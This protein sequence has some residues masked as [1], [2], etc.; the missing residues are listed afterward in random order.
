MPPAGWTKYV[1]ITISHRVYRGFHDDPDDNRDVT[2]DAQ[3]R[4]VPRVPGILSCVFVDDGKELQVTVV[5][6][7]KYWRMLGELP[8]K[9]IRVQLLRTDETATGGAKFVCRWKR[10]AVVGWSKTKVEVICV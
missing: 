1:P 5:H 3:G 2:V 9:V 7:V 8:A 6:K 4:T 10:K